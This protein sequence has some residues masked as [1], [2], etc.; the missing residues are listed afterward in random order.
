M[1]QHSIPILAIYTG[2]YIICV[3]EKHNKK[4]LH[5]CS[6]KGHLIKIDIFIFDLVVLGHS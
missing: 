4:V 5:D 6:T 1:V 3:S 2:G